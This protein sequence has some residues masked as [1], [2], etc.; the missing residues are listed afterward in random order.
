MFL[1]VISKIVP[2]SEIKDEITVFPYT[3]ELRVEVAKTWQNMLSVYVNTQS[4]IEN[5]HKDDK[6]GAL[7][8][9]LRIQHIVENAASMTNIDFDY[10]VVDFLTSLRD[11]HINHSING[12]HGCVILYKDILFSVVGT[13]DS[14][15][16][17]LSHT[18]RGVQVP[19]AG[20]ELLEVDG[21]PIKQYIKESKLQ[22]MGSNDFASLRTVLEQLSVRRGDI[23]RLPKET[24]TDFV[25]KSAKTNQTFAVTLPWIAY[26]HDS[27]WEKNQ[28]AKIPTHEVKHE[29]KN[30]TAQTT[31]NTPTKAPQTVFTTQ[32]QRSGLLIRQTRD[33]KITWAVYKL[34]LGDS[35]A[36]GV[37]FLQSFAPTHDV[38]TF[39]Q[40]IRSLLVN[41]LKNTDAVVVNV[42]SNGGGDP[43]LAQLIPQLF[44]SNIKT[45]Y[46]RV[47]IS[48][49]NRE[50]FES[51]DDN[52]WIEALAQ[53]KDGYSKPL[54]LIPDEA[55]NTIGQ[56]YFKP[57]GVF[58]DALCYSSCEIFT[59]MMKDNDIATI[60][61][62]DGTT[63][64]GGADPMQYQTLSQKIPNIFPPNTIFNRFRVSWKQVLRI[65]GSLI[66]D[67]GIPS[68]IIV[69]PSVSDFTDRTSNS[70]QYQKIAEELFKQGIDNG[71]NKLF[72]Q[73][74]PQNSAD[75]SID[76]DVAF[77]VESSGFSAIQVEQNGIV[78]QRKE[79]REESSEVE[80]YELKFNHSIQT[81]QI[82]RYCIRG[83]DFTR[84]NQFLTW[85]TVKFIPRKSDFLQLIPGKIHSLD[86]SGTSKYFAQYDHP[87]QA[88]QGWNTKNNILRIG[89]GVNY[90]GNMETTVSYFFR[91]HKSRPMIS[92]KLRYDTMKDRDVFNTGLIVNRGH[93]RD[94]GCGLTKLS[95]K[96]DIEF[97]EC[98]LRGIPNESSD[99]EL[100][101]KFASHGRTSTD[102]V[103]IESIQLWEP[104]S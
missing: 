88:G 10:N 34:G 47:I 50:F 62:E 95:G 40:A 37:I 63:G 102:G 41:E 38:D 33:R 51:N 74:M 21:K 7:D 4:K 13:G 60:F 35:K 36:L 77:K 94:L 61:G 24:H 42:V 32:A 75:I 12:T 91:T 11:K 1:N 85:R 71:K 84:K 58:T 15:K 54:K 78:H 25:F 39:I 57:V 79:F 104:S 20:D 5:H 87:T 92:I 31:K 73:A 22:T 17:I 6:N 2:Y 103:T 19:E 55:A 56:A 80:K 29:E 66:E 48:E 27:C 3:P 86:M 70:S 99:V 96:G 93:V 18:S 14:E 83:I 59:A 67:I 45:M 76:E 89:N 23:D 44:G 26:A 90:E 68:D 65:D 9:I 69:R 46:G 97:A 8:S 49:I 52:E 82:V 16:I 101:F 53:P 72:F 98:V 28:A 64:G 81:P 43:R 100:F 30:T